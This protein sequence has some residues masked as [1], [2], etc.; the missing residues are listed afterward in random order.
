MIQII[1]L[2]QTLPGMV[3]GEVLMSGSNMLLPLGTVI[4]TSHIE[5]LRHCGVSEIAVLSPSERTIAEVDEQREA[6]RGQ[7]ERLFRRAG[8]NIT[9]KALRRAVLEYQLEKLK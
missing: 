7:V 6:L 8:S 1:P 3:L 5:S 9:M 2:D 4:N